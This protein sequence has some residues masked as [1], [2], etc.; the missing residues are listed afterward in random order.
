MKNTILSKE[1]IINYQNYKYCSEDNTFLTKFYNKIWNQIQ[2]IIPKQITPNIITFMG[3]FSVITGFL[4]RNCEYGN[5][6]MGIGVFLYMN[7]DGLDGIHA[8]K[9]K[10]TS[11]IGEYLDHLIDL[12]NLS[13]I[14]KGL[15]EQ[16]G[17]EIN[18][19]NILISSLSLIFILP[20]YE[21]IYTKKIIFK[22]ISDVSLF[23]TL[24][25]LL[26]LSNFTI[27]DFIYKQNLFLFGAFILNLYS[28]YWIYQ[29]NKI[30]YI[31]GDN[32]ELGIPIIIII[33]YF[34][35]NIGLLFKPNNYLELSSLTD[36]LLLLDIINYKIFKIIPSIKLAFVPILFMLYPVITSMYIIYYLIN[37]IYGISK[38][39]EISIFKP[40]IKKIRVYCC[41]VFDLCHLGHMML[42]E[43][44][45]K[46]FNEPIELIVGIHSDKSCTDYKRAPIINERI[47]YETVAHCKYVDKVYVDAP[48]ITT[49]EFILDNK[50]DIVII[51]EEYKG[52]SDKHWY[53]GAFELSIY[54]YISRYDLI[55]TSD[56]IK[57]IKSDY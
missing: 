1:N 39:L 23:L 19:I 35:K 22:N 50:I 14:A 55:S 27:P 46:S 25:V 8:R 31:N 47:R 54:K 17:L 28:L 15:G 38:E 26:F 4:L 10:Q 16:F 12:T 6:Y 30:K 32:L 9:S 3:L 52:K 33:Y 36:T 2:K 5:I 29:I 40:K 37:F 45:S 24:T 7:F 18:T 13:L 43:K 11:V 48:L 41:G 42:F 21:A 49:R 53:P 44:I 34:I 57:K 51:G 20:H 56:I